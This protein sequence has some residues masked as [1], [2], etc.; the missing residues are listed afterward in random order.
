MSAQFN[1]FTVDDLLPL[2]NK[3][4]VIDAVRDALICHGRGKVQSPMPGHLLFPEV[5]GDCHIKS[6]HMVGSANFVIKVATGFYN[7]S[8]RGLPVN[9]GAVLVLDAQTGAPV[10]LFQ[11]DGW[12]TA[13]RTA[14]ATALAT[15][16]LAPRPDARVGVIGTG[17]Q[18]QLAIKWIA[19]LMPGAT[20][21]L[22]GRNTDRTQD[23]AN[24]L[25]I[26]AS[27][28]T[29]EL[30]SGSDIIVTA[31]PSTR[32]LFDANQACPG[33][34]FVGVG[35]DGPEKQELPETLFAR[36]SLIVTDDHRQCLALG[37]FGRAVRAGQIVESADTSFGAL[38][39]DGTNKRA[40][41]DITIID[42]TGLAAQDIAIA[43]LFAS[44]LSRKKGK[45]E[46]T[47]IL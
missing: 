11:D 15:H 32:A 21:T 30:L 26:L 24:D 20:F 46:L 29:E 19:E 8:M 40:T 16:C 7:N 28:S 17:L 10:S 31:T 9:N 27:S 12:L 6:G 33:M 18:G 2:L 34:H 47:T 39:E 14:A 36:A 37:D 41:G 4:M 5:N 22:L 23:I 13:W 35:A 42:L 25:G 45:S 38:L 3:R 43:N 1:I 44:L